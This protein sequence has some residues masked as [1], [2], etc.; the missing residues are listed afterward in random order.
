[1]ESMVSMA[2]PSESTHTSHSFLGVNAANGFSDI[3]FLLGFER[4]IWLQGPE[5]RK[6][7]RA[8]LCPRA[9]LQKVHRCVSHMPQKLSMGSLPLKASGP[10]ISSST[11]TSSV[12]GAE[13]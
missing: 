2:Q 11:S 6:G 7:A 9:F 10:A 12:A 5:S 1:M 8:A 3:I 13:S 4:F